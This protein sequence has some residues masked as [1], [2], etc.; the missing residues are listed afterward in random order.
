MCV[1]G[2]ACEVYRRETG[3]GEWISNSRDTEFVLNHTAYGIMMPNEVADWYGFDGNPAADQEDMMEWNDRLHW[4]FP[5][6][7]ERLKE[8]LDNDESIGY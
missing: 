2:M 6:M 3:E 1:E 8:A 7:A 5:R 4:S